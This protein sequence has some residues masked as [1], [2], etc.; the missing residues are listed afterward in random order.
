MSPITPLGDPITLL[1]ISSLEP[2]VN[3]PG[4]LFIS[5]GLAFDVEEFWESVFDAAELAELTFGVVEFWELV[6]GAAEL[7]ELTFGAMVL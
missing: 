4:W 1:T 3:V 6:F 5:C 7:V 2:A